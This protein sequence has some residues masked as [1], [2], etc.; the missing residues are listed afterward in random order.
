MP[1]KD[2]CTQLIEIILPKKIAEFLS[3]LRAD[4]NSTQNASK[5]SNC[6]RILYPLKCKD[7]DPCEELKTAI[8]GDWKNMA[9]W[10]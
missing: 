2:I 5:Q 4:S 10:E 1:K 6:P 7:I 9:D 3:A 8:I